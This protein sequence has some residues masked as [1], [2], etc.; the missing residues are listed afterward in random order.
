M[1]KGKRKKRK[2][3]KKKG[4]KVNLVFETTAFFKNSE[5][6]FCSKLRTIKNNEPQI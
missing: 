4:E 3:K 5:P 6:R 2:F 1:N